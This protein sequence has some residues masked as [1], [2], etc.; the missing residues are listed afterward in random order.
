MKIPK[1]VA[2]WTYYGSMVGM[3]ASVF[4]PSYF[5]DKKNELLENSPTH[6]GAKSIA[7]KLPDLE[8]ALLHCFP[9][10]REGYIPDACLETAKKYDR[11][12]GQFANLKIDSEYIATKDK[13]DTLD[14]ASKYA[15]MGLFFFFPLYLIGSSAYAN[16][17]REEW[18]EHN[19]K[20]AQKLK[21]MEEIAKRIKGEQ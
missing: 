18:L 7:E 20:L 3:L 13:A 21:E 11:L 5:S 4:S 1:T 2:K 12:L 14:K 15:P 16:R 6:L 8:W 9:R 10:S 17:R 19:P